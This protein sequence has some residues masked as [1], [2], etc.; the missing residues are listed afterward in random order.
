[1]RS[2]SAPAV[3]DVLG[4]KVTPVFPYGIG[5][6][7]HSRFIAVCALVQGK[8]LLRFE[9][10]FPT[11]IPGLA[12]AA[13]WARATLRENRKAIGKFRYTLESTG[14]YH[15]PVIYSFAGT[16]T[17]VN[18]MLAGQARRKTDKLDARLLAYHSLTGLW[19]VS[20]L[21]PMPV[22]ELRVLILRRRQVLRSR[23]RAIN[24]INNVLLRYGHTIGSS[25]SLSCATVRP[26][27]EDLLERRN[28]A[29]PYLSL[30]PLPESTVGVVKSLYRRFD[31]MCD[32]E[33]EITRAAVRCAREMT[34]NCDAGPI[35]GSKLM[36]LPNAG[37]MNFVDQPEMWQKAVQG[38]LTD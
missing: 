37:H 25:G 20:Y 14:C 16:P 38:F 18:P 30:I 19:R 2:R 32:E 21:P 27:V 17:I 3:P 13:K 22:Q 31:A 8:D 4:E 24:T 23:S 5:I 26:I 7:C 34:F 1:M 35:A 28:V 12:D 29:S 15:L 6:D 10:Q 11:T 9:R 33:R 36:I